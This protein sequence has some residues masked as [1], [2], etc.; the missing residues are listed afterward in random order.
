M[1]GRIGSNFSFVCVLVFLEMC[2]YV[3]VFVFCCVC[4]VVMGCSLV[5][6]GVHG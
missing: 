4:V 1:E 6:V 2:A 5:Q 3:G